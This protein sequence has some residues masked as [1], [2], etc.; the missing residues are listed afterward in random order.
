MFTDP[1]SACVLNKTC[2]AA[3]E[4]WRDYAQ[5]WGRKTIMLTPSPMLFGLIHSARKEKCSDV[6]CF[7]ANMR[8]KGLK[9]VYLSK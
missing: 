2:L 6:R 3:R 7:K 8:N 4:C 9:S 5:V 1:G